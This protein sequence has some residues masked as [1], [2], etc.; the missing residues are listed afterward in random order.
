MKTKIL[1]IASLFGAGG[2]MMGAFG[3]HALKDQ[4]PALSLDVIRTGVLYLFVHVMAALITTALANRDSYTGPIRYAGISF[5]VGVL[6]FSGSLFII[7]TSSL[8]GIRASIIGPI[9]PLGGLSFILGW[10]FLGWWAWR[11]P[12]ANKG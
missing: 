9:T 2:V 10:A 5:L 6:L 4:L 7:G 11:R 1:L 8:T 3:A 12:T